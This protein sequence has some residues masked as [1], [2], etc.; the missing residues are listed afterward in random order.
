MS[1]RDVERAMVVFKYMYGMMDVFG[2]LMD[3]W[4]EKKLAT[5]AAEDGSKEVS[6]FRHGIIHRLL[7]HGVL[8]D[9]YW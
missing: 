8:A 2:P 1:L 4:A 9:Q 7:G 3:H 5:H 6:D